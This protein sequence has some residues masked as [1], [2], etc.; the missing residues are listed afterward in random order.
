MEARQFPVD[1]VE[2]LRL[3]HVV[4]LKTWSFTGMPHADTVIFVNDEWRI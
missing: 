4:T 1:V 2:Y 3:H